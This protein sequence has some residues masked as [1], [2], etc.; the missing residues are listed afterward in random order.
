MTIE[1]VLE[2]RLRVAEGRILQL[3]AAVR[4]L[5]EALL[6]ERT[7][8]AFQRIGIKS[9]SEGFPVKAN[10]PSGRARTYSES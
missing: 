4:L 8:H 1:D 6:E 10:L 5:A 2:Q 7:I 3:E 9:I